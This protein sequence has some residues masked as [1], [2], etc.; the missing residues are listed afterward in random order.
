[1]QG[2]G[3]IKSA[4]RVILIILAVLCFAAIL[5]LLVFSVRYYM[6]AH[7][8]KE[9]V[10]KTDT[11]FKMNESGTKIANIPYG[12]YIKDCERPDNAV[13][14]DIKES[15]S[16]EENSK[17]INDAVNSLS[18]GGT[19]VIP[20]GEYR[21]GTI[22]LKSNITLFAESGAKLVSMTAEENKD[23]DVPL[24]GAV[25]YAE[26]AENITLTGGGTICGSGESYTLSPEDESPL[27]ALKEFN[28]Y[29]RVIEARHRIRFAS[30]D[31]RSKLVCFKNCE[32]VNI[33]NI[34]LSDSAEWTCVIDGCENVEIKD[35]VI[36]NNMHVANTDGIDV[37]GSSLVNIS[38]CFIATGDD[39]VVLKSPE[40]EINDVTV[41]DCVLSSLANCFKIG[42]ETA[43]DVKN[44]RIDNCYF[45]L[46]DGITGGYSG[47]A[48]ESADGAVIQN[49][50]AENITMDGVSSPVLIWLGD[51]LKY[52][53]KTVGGIDGVVIKNVSAQNTEMPSAITG[54]KYDGEIYRVKN[55][56]LQN[57]TA[58]YRDTSENLSVKKNVSDGSMNDYPEITRISHRYFISHEMSDYYDLP[59]YSLFL[60]YAENTDYSGLKTTPRSC[61]ER[62]ELYIE[63][64]IQ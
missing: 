8:N 6:K 18:N 30:G 39:A 33:N 9:T 42:T 46:P 24:S 43:F 28:L 62:D 64:Y 59:C 40:K 1:M 32:N 16:G 52:D 58:V 17:A 47:I 5:V 13:I 45:F 3:F 31:K 53:K 38:H 26:N 21:V 10:G 29:T 54:C 44:V 57:V 36:D 34:V 23:S 49:V 55:V 35:V 11:E 19:V 60:R 48:I 2:D 37:Y 4:K 15:A 61:N 63:D 56:S 20:K 25:I 7:K 51:R 27:Y 41:T 12:E 50:T 14:P 22:T